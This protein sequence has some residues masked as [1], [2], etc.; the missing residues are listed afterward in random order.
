MKT[1][2]TSLIL[3]TIVSLH[4]VAQDTSKWG[5]PEGA[6]AR[7]DKGK[8]YE[9]KY[10]PDG[11]RLAVGCSS[12]VWLYDSVTG[13]LVDLIRSGNS[14]GAVNV[15]F[16]RDGSTFAAGADDIICVWDAVTGEKKSTYELTGHFAHNRIRHFAF[17]P[18]GRTLA[19]GIGGGVRLWDVVT[20]KSKHGLFGERFD[21]VEH[22]A[23]SPDGRILAS[24]HRS[25]GARHSTSG[26]IGLWDV[27]TGELKTSLTAFLGL[28][29]SLA[30]SPDGRT[31]ASGN[32]YSHIAG[33]EWGS[34]NLWDVATWEHKLVLEPTFTGVR[35]G[36]GVFSIAYSPDGRTLASGHSIDEYNNDE[37][38]TVR[39][40]D[41]ET[42]ENI[43]TLDGHPGGVNSVAF[44]R[45]GGT[46]AIASGSTRLALWDAATGTQKRQLNGYSG[47]VASVAFSPDGRTVA[48]GRWGITIDLWDAATGSH[49]HTLKGHTEPTTSIAFSPTSPILASGSSVHRY[50]SSQGGTVRLWDTVTGAHIYTL[51]GQGSAITSVAFSPDG[52]TLASGGGV[53]RLYDTATGLQIRK[54]DG[55]NRNIIGVAFSPDGET[56]AGASTEEIRL[57]NAENGT[58]KR[59]LTVTSGELS[60]DSVAFSA[61]GGAL[62]AGGWYSIHLWNT[63]TGAHI[64]T[65]ERNRGSYAHVVY[66]P[67]ADTF[68]AYSPVGNTI[69]N[70][71]AFFSDK[72]VRLWDAETGDNI[73]TLEGHSRDV[74]GVAFGPEGRTLASGSLDG[75]VLLWE[76]IP[77]DDARENVVPSQV[78]PDVNG[79]GVVDMRDLV[80]VAGRLGKA[81]ENRED[82]NGDGVVNILDLVLVA[83]MIDNAAGAPLID[84]HG[85]IMLRTTDVKQWLEGARRL[86]LADVI[87]QR[88]MEYLQN[89][90]DILTPERTAMLPKLPESVQSGDVDSVSPR[91]RFGCPNLNL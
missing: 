75:T 19:V 34:I 86:A 15:V 11:T 29:K 50:N 37:F 76:I 1:V 74:L 83:G 81:A 35:D 27:E 49:R 51:E 71:A 16:S 28:P 87:S 32:H 82:V 73:R 47:S 88:G 18:D 4:T 63:E 38:G 91:S 62:A 45:D 2:F 53:L 30:F 26:I 39:L 69:A 8:I 61:D 33:D 23:F 70:G 20:G 46:L 17:S 9:V 59:T 14:F 77:K 7:L 13:D 64:R 79:D 56:L 80:L 78:T 41:V 43:R 5:L 48:S 58:L 24:G 42:G 66:S 68:I 44:S 84:S 67:N 89:L 90:L 55:Q 10:S 54:L 6:K 65:L 57:W 85:A 21:D 60:R 52:R 36:G 25:P 31:L 22:L 3:F 72:T 40:W 12:G